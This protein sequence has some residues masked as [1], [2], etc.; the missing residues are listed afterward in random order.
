V[1]IANVKRLFKNVAPLFL[2]LIANF[3]EIKKML[4]LHAYFL[5]KSIY[6]FPKWDTSFQRLQSCVLTERSAI[7]F[8]DKIKIYGQSRVAIIFFSHKFI[9][10]KCYTSA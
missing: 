10:E 3:P 4:F 9:V 8:A 1:F 6:K 2:F 7:F 5:D